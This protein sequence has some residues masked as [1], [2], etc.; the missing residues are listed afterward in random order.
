[1]K[2]RYSLLLLCC[3]SLP[4][5]AAQPSLTPQLYKKF[6]Q[7]Q[8]LIAAANWEKALQA[9]QPLSESKQAYARALAWQSKGQIYLQ[10]KQLPQA[11]RA[12]QRALAEQALPSQ[13]QRQVQHALARVQLHQQQWQAGTAGLADWLQWA[14]KQAKSGVELAD[15]LALAQGYQQLGQKQALLRL[16]ETV[17][18][19]WWRQAEAAPLLQLAVATAVAEQDYPGAARWQQHWL[20]HQQPQDGAAWLQLANLQIRA[21]QHS[22]AL[23]SLRL[24]WQQRLLDEQGIELLQQLYRHQ[25]LPMRAAEVLQQA[26]AE[27]RLPASLVWQQHLA[28]AYLQAKAYEQGLAV[29][30]AMAEQQP[31]TPPWLL[32]LAQLQLQLRQ[33]Q[34]ALHTLEQ[35]LATPQADLATAFTLR[36]IALAHQ[37]RWQEA[38]QAL[39]QALAQQPQSAQAQLWLD[40]IAQRQG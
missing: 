23:A 36:G 17:P 40:Y 22:Q 21:G 34:P 30:V 6:T 5:W 10:Q 28:D 38:E 25:G 32:R 12:F 15:Y 11:E 39:Q 9:L 31:Q 20:E 26:M 29:L 2:A 33:W 37:Q 3:L 24:A 7:A 13:D 19:A 1:M 14:Q 16:L 27:Q 8:E 35:V 18:S 4:L